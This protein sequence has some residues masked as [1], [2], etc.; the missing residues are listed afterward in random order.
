MKVTTENNAKQFALDRI[1]KVYIG[2]D[3]N[4]E[5]TLNYIKDYNIDLDRID[6]STIEIT[7]ALDN[8]EIENHFSKDSHII[9][10]HIEA[11]GVLIESD[12]IIDVF[13]DIPCDMKIRR[14]KI[15]ADVGTCQDMFV[16][17]E[18]IVK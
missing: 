15:S 7:N 8:V 6:C 10:V 1:K 13:Y 2:F 9:Y 4:I 16:E 11:S 14:F 3:D 17:L 18:G 5:V 12:E